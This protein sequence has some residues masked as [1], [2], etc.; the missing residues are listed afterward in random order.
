MG[1]YREGDRVICDNRLA[2]VARTRRSSAYGTLLDLHFDGDD[3]V[4]LSVWHELMLDPP[5]LQ[6]VDA[7]R[8]SDR[9]QG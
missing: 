4:T 2:T 5:T 3:K 9:G 8:S 7:A 6:R 1:E